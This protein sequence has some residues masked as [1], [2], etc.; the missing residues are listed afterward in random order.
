MAPPPK[1]RARSC[2]GDLDLAAQHH[3]TGRA[4]FLLRK[5]HQVA[6]AVFSDEVGAIPLTPPQHNVLS[7]LLSHPGCHQT[8]MGR[9]VGYDRATVGTV[10]NGL[11]ARSLLL[12]SSSAT[13]KRLKTLTLTPKGRQLLKASGMAMDRINERVLAPLTPQERPAFL[14][15]LAR[16]A[17]VDTPEAAD[18][19]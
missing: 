16:V 13:D 14:A 19:S 17:L 10:V 6:V 8:E 12:R 9:L 2:D 11:A 3:L 4:G 7:M 18:G 15:M 5:A 1:R